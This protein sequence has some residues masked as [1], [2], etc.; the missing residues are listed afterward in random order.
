[1]KDYSLH[2]FLVAYKRNAKTMYIEWLHISPFLWV[3]WQM[4]HCCILFRGLLLEIISTWE[5]ITEQWNISQFDTIKI[6]IVFFIII[7]IYVTICPCFL[8]KKS[9]RKLHPLRFN[10]CILHSSQCWACISG[11]DSKRGGNE[12]LPFQSDVL[13]TESQVGG[14]F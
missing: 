13:L 3:S 10:S 8:N 1:M 4:S 2:S 12:E 14:R 11:L 9:H 6:D 5:A 7:K